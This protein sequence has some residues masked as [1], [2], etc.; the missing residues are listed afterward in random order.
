ML[1]SILPFVRLFVSA[2]FPAGVAA[3]AWCSGVA[4]RHAAS[5]MAP[6]AQQPVL[7]LATRSLLISS[8]ARRM[9]CPSW[10]LSGCR[11]L[12]QQ[13]GLLA[14]WGWHSLSHFCADIPQ[15]CDLSCTY[16]YVWAAG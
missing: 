15:V 11:R 7:W 3:P 14:Q 13:Q 16:A 10:L 12:G 5:C 8:L 1:L 4:R 2:G 6:S 9:H